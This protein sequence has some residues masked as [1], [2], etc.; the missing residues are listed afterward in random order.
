MV[1]AGFLD[2]DIDTA[3]RGLGFYDIKFYINRRNKIDIACKVV[4]FDLLKD[5]GDFLQ[6]CFDFYSVDRDAAL[7]LLTAFGTYQVYDR[8]D[9]IGDFEY[10]KDIKPI[11][12]QFSISEYARE[13]V[14]NLTAQ[15]IDNLL[16]NV[17]EI[18]NSF[19]ERTEVFHK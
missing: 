15:T 12:E 1:I 4:A 5:N 18:L 14:E 16:N 17:L 10:L 13:G 7:N 8:W 9:W 19:K 3:L 6:N 2:F 11:C